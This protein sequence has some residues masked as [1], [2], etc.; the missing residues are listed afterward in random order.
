MD[1]RQAIEKV[2]SNILSI[3][4]RQGLDSFDPEIKMDLAEVLNMAGERLMALSEAK[5]K[6]DIQDQMEPGFIDSSNVSRFQYDPQNQSL[7]VQFK[8]KYPNFDG[9]IYQYGGI[10][11]QLAELIQLG[12]EQATTDGS[13]EWGSWWKGKTPSLGAAVAHILKAGGFSYQKLAA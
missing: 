12:A 2:L 10:P 6:I 3:I 9:P 5:A 11:P 13:N 8:G 1:E 7:K 4:E